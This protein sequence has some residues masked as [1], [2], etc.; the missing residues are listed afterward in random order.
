[1]T[2][3]PQN[4]L[5][6]PEAEPH[7]VE[8][9]PKQDRWVVPF[10]VIPLGIALAILSI[11]GVANFL[12]G[13]GEPR[14]I[15]EL[16][17]EVKGGG[18][19]ARKQA[20]FHLA[21]NI[22]ED[23]EKRN[24]E[25]DNQHKPEA[26]DP[27]YAPPRIAAPRRD[28]LKIETAYDFVKDDHETR[29]FLVA[30]LG[31]VGDDETADFLGRKLRDPDFKDP[32]GTLKVSM[33][34]A[35]ARICS[36]RAMPAFDAE[37]ER[38]SGGDSDAGTMNILAAGYGNIDSPKATQK[39]ISILQFSAGRDA[40]D[41]RGTTWREVRWTAAVNL[42]KRRDSDP[43]AAKLAIP[44]LMSGIEDV[45]ADASRPDHERLFRGSGGSG[46]FLPTG[47]TSQG[48]ENRQ[49]AAEQLIAALVF[50]DARDAV[51]IL[52]KVSTADPNLRIR[53]AA[54]TALAKLNPTA[55]PK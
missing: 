20:A 38:A 3:T 19:N 55:Q 36:E 45:F 42:A 12:L 24:K 1:M 41:A 11:I 48:D 7:A 9:A 15:D 44:V 4:P 16:L 51:S 5:P 54:I 34:H 8:S 26:N 29:R 37:F 6:L 22:A 28:L 47:V 30:A 14:S 43:A 17:D 18:A 31:L 39:L 52:K 53:S 46:S 40:K 49:S 50:L 32:D 21:R 33:L 2:E 13:R 35:M 27:K 10:V 23:V 25:L